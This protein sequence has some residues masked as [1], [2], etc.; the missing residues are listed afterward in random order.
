MRRELRKIT[1]KA[2]L[3]IAKFLLPSGVVAFILADGRI[4]ECV[5]SRGYSSKAARVHLL[6][7]LSGAAA[8]VIYNGV[9]MLANAGDD[10]DMALNAIGMILAVTFAGFAVKSFYGVTPGAAGSGSGLSAQPG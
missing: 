1:G 5:Q 8:G 9:E 2:V 6:F 10:V 4:E 7:R 3:A